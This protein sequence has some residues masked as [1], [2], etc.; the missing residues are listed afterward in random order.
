MSNIQGTL[1]MEVTYCF[2]ALEILCLTTRCPKFQHSLNIEALNSC[3]L[4]LQK[5]SLTITNPKFIYIIFKTRFP[6]SYVTSCLTKTTRNSLEGLYYL[7]CITRNSCVH[8][9]ARVILC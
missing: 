8:S 7:C 3:S 5:L 2:E 4:T 1:R 9:V 6:G